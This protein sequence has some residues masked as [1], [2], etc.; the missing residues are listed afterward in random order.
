MRPQ[1]WGLVRQ[2]PEPTGPAISAWWWEREEGAEQGLAA[3]S[4]W[5]G[6]SGAELGGGC[7]RGRAA[8]SE[9]TL[10]T[11]QLDSRLSGPWSCAR[12]SVS[13]APLLRRQLLL[14]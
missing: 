2:G 13:V 12:R 11:A 10:R 9:V 5:A 4:S 7:A 8:G 6:H 3:C 1:E 14:K